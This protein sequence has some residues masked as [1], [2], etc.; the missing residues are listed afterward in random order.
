MCGLR[1]NPVSVSRLDALLDHTSRFLVSRREPTGLSTSTCALYE[2]VGR[3]WYKGSSDDLISKLLIAPIEVGAAGKPEI[4]Q[5]G[6]LQYIY[7]KT[8]KVPFRVLHVPVCV[9]ATCG[10]V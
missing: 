5:I 10:R 3:E 7:L 2:D 6:L 8:D 9:L 4:H 1:G